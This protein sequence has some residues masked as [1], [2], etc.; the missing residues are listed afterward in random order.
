MTTSDAVDK[1]E[2]SESILNSPK[3]Q[4][5]LDMVK[6]DLGKQ[7]ELSFAMKADP[8]GELW[9]VRKH[10]YGHPL[11]VKTGL[12]YLSVGDQINAGVVTETELTLPDDDSVLPE[13]TKFQEHGTPIIDARPFLGF[14][15]VTLDDAVAHGI[16]ELTRQLLEAWA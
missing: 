16:D 2:L 9:P 15:E 1:M 7:A 3:M 4:T 14:G 5:A 13:Y 6:E 12:M 11:L 8:D 10:E